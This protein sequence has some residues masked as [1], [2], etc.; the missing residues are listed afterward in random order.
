[1]DILLT[2]RAARNLDAIVQYIAV[3]WGQ[4]A[5]ATFL[6]KVDAFFN[7]LEKYPGIVQVEKDDI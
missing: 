7:V 6:E 5:S 4:S 1:M 2:K 3:T